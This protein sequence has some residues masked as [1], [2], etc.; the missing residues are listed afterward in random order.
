MTTLDIAEEA[1]DGTKDKSKVLDK[2]TKKRIELYGHTSDTFDY[3]F[4]LVFSK[5]F[6]KFARGGK[7]TKI[8]N[9]EYNDFI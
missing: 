6:N 3:V 7:D 9:V 4:C 8:V 5:E 2:K 1:I